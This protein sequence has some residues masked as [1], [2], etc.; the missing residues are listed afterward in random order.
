[1][2]EGRICSPSESGESPSDEPTTRIGY[3]HPDT[4]ITYPHAHN[5]SGCAQPIRI[6]ES[7]SRGTQTASRPGPAGLV[8]VGDLAGCAAR[9]VRGRGVQ[10][11]EI[12]QAS[13]QP[14]IW[15]ATPN[16][17]ASPRKAERK[18]SPGPN[19]PGDYRSGWRDLNPRPLRP[20]RSALPSCATPRC[21][22]S[23]AFPR[24]YSQTEIKQAA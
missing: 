10:V 22:S 19:G 8:V 1:M 18:K 2:A 5:L 6:R 21:R 3:E 15:G 17:A 24:R 11:S 23:I 16:L 12:R 4:L 20:E 9:P 7:H 14:E 13:W